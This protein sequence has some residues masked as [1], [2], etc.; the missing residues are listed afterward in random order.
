MNW[1]HYISSDPRICHGQVCVKGTRIPV[2]V[3]LD[4]LASG[5][6][7]QEVVD[8]YPDSLTLDAVMAVLAYASVLSREKVV[9]LDQVA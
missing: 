2:T 4:N 5:L 6:T 3:V 7:P 8:T 9:E 1:Q